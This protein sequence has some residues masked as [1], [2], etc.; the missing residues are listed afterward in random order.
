MAE[1]YC[2][3]ANCVVEELPCPWCDAEEHERVE[4]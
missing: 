1:Y 4:L 3:D 2:P